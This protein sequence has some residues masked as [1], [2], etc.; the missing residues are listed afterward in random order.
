MRKI[1]SV[2]PLALFI[3]MALGCESLMKKESK[4]PCSPDSSSEETVSPQKS[5]GYLASGPT[6]SIDT[7]VEGK[8][9][10]LL[11]QFEQTRRD[12][13][14]SL[15]KIA[16]LE[17]ELEGERAIRISFEAELEELKKQLEATQQIIIENE[18]LNKKLEQSQEPYERK[19]R[20]LTLELT[21]AQIE[22]TKAKQE[23]IGLKIE[24][25]VEKK[26]Q[27]SENSQ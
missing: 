6:V 3:F 9:A 17:R 24:Q 26:K 18:K 11:E 4:K 5:S 22:E 27:K 1:L 16:L 23:L 13:A 21:K 19:I 8:R 10:S 15:E 12:L 25:L 7:G 2:I 20:E 14:S